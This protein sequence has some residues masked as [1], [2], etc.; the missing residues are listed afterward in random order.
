MVKG[1]KC[2]LIEDNI[3]LILFGVLN[4]KDFH[5]VKKYNEPL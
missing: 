3:N 5:N 2:T 4:F 1:Y